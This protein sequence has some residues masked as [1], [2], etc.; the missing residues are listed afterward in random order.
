VAVAVTFNFWRNS[1][2]NNMRRK[3]LKGYAAVVALVAAAL[4]GCGAVSESPVSVGF[5][6]VGTL[7]FIKVSSVVNE[8]TITG[9][10][11]NRG[12]CRGPSDLP[13]TLKFGEYV[14]YPFSECSNLIEITIE[15]NKGD[16]DFNI[17]AE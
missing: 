7:R 15:T 10:T 5:D 12:N 11:V 16:F 13:K 3:N 9:I 1:L 17:P 2:T 14:G 6:Y 8:V 4:G